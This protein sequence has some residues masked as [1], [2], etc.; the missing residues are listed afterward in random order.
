MK[1]S[2]DAIKFNLNLLKEVKLEYPIIQDYE[3]GKVSKSTVSNIGF[4]SFITLID[5]IKQ[6]DSSG[7]KPIYDEEIKF[8][9]LKSKIIELNRVDSDSIFKNKTRK[10]FDEIWNDYKLIQKYKNSRNRS[11]AP[12]L[13][14]YIKIVLKCVVIIFFI[15]SLFGLIECQNRNSILVS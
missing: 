4:D 9:D 10:K 14:I 13:I 12:G 7:L 6:C 8:K 5:Y 3:D 15:G 1:V 2:L 11:Y